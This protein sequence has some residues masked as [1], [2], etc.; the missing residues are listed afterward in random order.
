[1]VSV[2]FYIRVMREEDDMLFLLTYKKNMPILF[3]THA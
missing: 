3:I 1:M 2:R